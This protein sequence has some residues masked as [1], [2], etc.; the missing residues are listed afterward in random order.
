M[1]QNVENCELTE[2]GIDDV[3]RDDEGDKNDT[4]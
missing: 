1:N 4:S 2:N 3:E